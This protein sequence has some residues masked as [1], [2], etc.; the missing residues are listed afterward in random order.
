MKEKDDDFIGKEFIT[1][2]GGILTVKER[3]YKNKHIKYIC[4]C[5][6]CSEDKELFPYGSISSRKE[7]IQKGN[8]PCGC[9]K[10]RKWTEEQNIIRVNRACVNMGYI[11]H[12]WFGEYKGGRTRLDLSNPRN[13]NRWYTNTVEGALSGR[14]DRLE[15]FENTR[16]SNIKPDKYHIQNFNKAG[17]TEGY[18]FWRSD[19]IS[20]RGYKDYWY[21]T[22]PKCSN[23]EYVQNGLCSGVFESV[24]GSL[25]CGNKSCR[26]GRTYQWTQEQREYQ[27]NK[28]CSA[29]RLSFLKWKDFEGYKNNKSKML[30]FCS[31][32]HKCETYVDS[33]L[34]GTRCSTCYNIKKRTMGNG[35]GYYPDRVNEKDYL[36]ILNFKNY[37]K[38]GR[39]FN[40]D[41]RMY[42]IIVESDTV[43]ENIEILQTLTSNHQ[44]VYD[45]EQW[46]HEE[47]R[48]RGFEY[49]EPDGMWSTE[50]FDLDCI[51]VLNYLLKQT[52]LDV[53]EDI[54]LN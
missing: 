52:D 18:K 37:I 31:K 36:Y 2:K 27:I 32:G 29:E 7:S 16:L 51:D 41:S 15:N 50:L 5:S 22:C 12:G 13:N 4:E 6:I 14:G 28:I 26:C 34:Y 49:N 25:R 47:L 54:N 39:T 19:R 24:I 1:P 42:G 10:K 17:F 30:W 23:D 38:V 3:Y 46:L 48:E 21:Y 43:R 33:F 53:C 20:G 35:N 9:A 44:T 40:I 11:F 8:I 45:T